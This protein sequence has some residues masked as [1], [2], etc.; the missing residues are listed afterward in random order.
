MNTL[1]FPVLQKRA[2]SSA[3]TAGILKACREGKFPLEIDASEG[4]FT[5][6]L[7]S[8]IYQ[9]RPGTYLAVV[10]SDTE[11]GALGRDLET[12]G[13]PAVLFPWWGTMPYR[14]ISP[15][16]AVFGERSAALSSLAAGEQG[17]FIV[18]QRAFLTP[19]PPPDYLRSLL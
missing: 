2:A 4:A 1:S 5:A 12:A 11:A 3:S 7:M 16:S 8:L 19:L 18:P 9:V 13:V 15:L 10:S 17:V 6:V 14:E